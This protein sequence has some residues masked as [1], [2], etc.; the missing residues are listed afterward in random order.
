MRKFVLHLVTAASAALLCSVCAAGGLP[1]DE[2]ANAAEQ[3]RVAEQ[4]AASEHKNVLL[5]FGANW[6]PDCRALDSALHDK[7]AAALEDRFVIVKVNVGDFNKNLDL[8]KRYQ[9]PLRKGIPAVAVVGAD[10]AVR[11]VT[12]E[13]E[14]ADARQMGGPAILSLL[15]RIDADGAVARH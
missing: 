1:Y 6:C 10:G 14:L 15:S 5:V 2:Q 9:V 12:K 3:I 4:T 8:A 7:N 13:G 11:Y